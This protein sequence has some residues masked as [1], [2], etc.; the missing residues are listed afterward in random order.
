LKKFLDADTE[1][2]FIV[3]SLQSLK[4]SCIKFR[5]DEDFLLYLYNMMRKKKENPERKVIKIKKS[6]LDKTK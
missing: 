6:S 3:H 4:S 2:K 1:V 5:G